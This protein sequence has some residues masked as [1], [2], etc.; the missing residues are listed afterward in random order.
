MVNIRAT[1]AAAAYETT[2]S[3]QFAGDLTKIAKSIFYKERTSEAVLQA[4]AADRPEPP[5]REL[6]ELMLQGQIDQKR[7]D[8]EM[9]LHTIDVNCHR[10][11]RNEGQ[12]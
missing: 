8:A 12:L 7:R 5:L 2:L 10:P 9:M 3:L 6:A 11:D 4:V 1:V